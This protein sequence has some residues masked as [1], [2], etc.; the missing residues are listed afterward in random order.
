MIFEGQSSAI[1]EHSRK[2]K[3]SLIYLPKRIYCLSTNNF[4]KQDLHFKEN[5][6][7][8]VEDE[9]KLF[10]NLQFKI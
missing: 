3:Y 1:R 9:K 10:K 8:I 6:I 4:I 2:S 5:K 7:K